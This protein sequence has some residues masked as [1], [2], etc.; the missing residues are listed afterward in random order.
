VGGAHAQRGPAD[1]AAGSGHGHGHG[2]AHGE[3]PDLPVRRGPR[4]VLLSVLALAA[5]ATVIG[6]VMLWPDPAKAPA[7]LDFFAPGDVAVQG[8]IES[9]SKPCATV[10][11]PAAEDC[12]RLKV[13]VDGGPVASVS[14][15]PY[16]LT[17][18]LRAGDRVDLMKAP[19]QAGAE[20]SYQFFG[21]DR[22][23]PI[24]LLVVA[25]VV[26]VALVARL[27]GVMALVGLVIAGGVLWQFVLP[28]LLSGESGTAVAL[29]GSA[30]IM[31]VVLYLAHGPSL[32][33]SAALA[34]TLVGVGI[35]AAIGLWA[36]DAAHLA[37][38]GDETGDILYT[39]SPDVNFR[40]LLT[41]AVIV[42]GLGVLNDVTITQASAVWELRA[43]AP[44]LSRTRVFASAMRIGRDHI[45]STIYTI[46]F[47]YAGTSLALLML[48]SLY[49]R[50]LLDLV[51]DEAIAEEIVRTL[52]SALGLVLAVPATTAIAVATVGSAIARPGQQTNARSADGS[53]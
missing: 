46:V 5:V 43:A 28:A 9:V 39:S 25:F 41:C 32:R 2:H 7:R 21:A 52:A 19:A 35:T 51:S 45:A 18:G 37:G 49:Q 16:V 47:A 10:G 11:G 29:V 48:L 4:A 1:K 8:T 13:K 34:G 36:L 33:T 50:P 27:R 40:G 44:E 6:L 15:P 53:V 12:N 30:A 31:F 24:G 38:V 22:D 14:V 26:V 23:L 3:A 20:A 42:A 17:S